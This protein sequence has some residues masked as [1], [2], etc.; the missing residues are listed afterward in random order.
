MKKFSF[1]LLMTVLAASMSAQDRRH[2]QSA[3]QRFSPERFEA[4]LQEYITKEANLTQQEA[5]KFFPVYKEMQEKQRIQFDRQREQSKIKPT[6]EQ[7]C[8]KAIKESDEIDLELKRIQQ[9]YHCRFLELMPASKVYDILKAEQNFYRHM[10]KNWGRGP[11][12]WGRGFGQGFGQSQQNW[13]RM[14]QGFG[15]G[16]HRQG[17]PGNNNQR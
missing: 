9:N 2:Q 1:I 16:Q 10:M 13:P 14:P 4:Q 3:E 5:A 7:G 11:Q 15:Q 12:N 17:P 8:M 6:D